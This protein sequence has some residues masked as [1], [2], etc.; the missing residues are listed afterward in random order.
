MGIDHKIKT[1]KLHSKQVKVEVWDT[2]G[3]EKFRS[4]TRSQFG[5]VSSVMLVFDVTDQSAMDNLN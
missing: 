3:H 2:A 5:G 1:I 4:L